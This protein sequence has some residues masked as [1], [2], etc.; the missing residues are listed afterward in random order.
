MSKNEARKLESMVRDALTSP[1]YTPE[2]DDV[3]DYWS[4]LKIFFF[5]TKA[6]LGIK[7][8]VVSY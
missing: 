6:A 3:V 2:E 1:N 4:L 7:F 5:L 8:I